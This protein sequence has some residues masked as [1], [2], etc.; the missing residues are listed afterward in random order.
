MAPVSVARPWVA[1]ASSLPPWVRH[2]LSGSAWSGF[3]PTPHQRHHRNHQENL[4]H[5]RDPMPPPS[6]SSSSP[7]GGS[8]NAL[9]GVSRALRIRGRRLS[10][11][12]NAFLQVQPRPSHVDDC[13]D[14]CN[15]LKEFPGRIRDRSRHLNPPAPTSVIASTTPGVEPN[16]ERHPVRGQR[17][18]YF[19]FQIAIYFTA[20]ARTSFKIIPH[21]FHRT[22]F[23]VKNEDQ[24]IISA[25]HSPILPNP[26]TTTLLQ[27]QSF[28]H[29]TNATTAHLL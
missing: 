7:F 17:A 13:E 23:G 12:G 21:K 19:A 25:F 20:N 14:C 15:A 8:G 4:F 28:S 22:W 24:A 1:P 18:R 29:P 10:Q 2:W 26:V 27:E 16:L 3:L 6:T 5:A 9:Q 11:I